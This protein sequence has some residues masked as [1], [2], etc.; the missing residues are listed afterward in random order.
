MY[1]REG[2]GRIFQRKFTRYKSTFGTTV[3][4]IITF[5]AKSSL[6]VKFSSNVGGPRLVGLLWPIVLRSDDRYYNFRK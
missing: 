4:I 6:V 3:I 5:T 2:G 1:Y